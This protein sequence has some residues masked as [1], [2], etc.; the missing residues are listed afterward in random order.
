MVE[1]TALGSHVKPSDFIASAI[2]TVTSNEIDLLLKNLPITPED[3]YV[4]DEENP[5]DGWKP[6][7]FH[8]L[9]VGRDRGNAGRIKLANQ[10]ANP[11]AERAVN[12][13][14]AIIEMARQRELV[15]APNATAPTSPRD[16][17]NRYFG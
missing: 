17:V 12:G 2:R 8:W 6:G 14:E 16:A 11:I 1:P 5:A 10:P 9:P 4:F 13:M 7:Y 3:E 15:T